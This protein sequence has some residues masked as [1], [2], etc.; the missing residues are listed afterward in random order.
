LSL[1]YTEEIIREYLSKYLLEHNRNML[2]VS[3]IR[4][5][6]CLRISFDATDEHVQKAMNGLTEKGFLN[7]HFELLTECAQYISVY[8]FDELHRGLSDDYET[9]TFEDGTYLNVRRIRKYYSIEDGFLLDIMTSYTVEKLHREV[10]F[11]LDTIK[12]QE[13][14]TYD[15][16]TARLKEISEYLKKLIEKE[17]KHGKS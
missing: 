9:F 16:R 2:T 15:Q 11:L 10:I 8:G 1:P 14:E 4:N 7:V 12:E 5:G 3:A 6:L 13:Q 17:F